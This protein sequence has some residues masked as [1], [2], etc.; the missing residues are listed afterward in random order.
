MNEFDLIDWIRAETLHGRHDVVLGIG[1]DAAVLD[2]PSDSQLVVSTDTLVAG[3]HFP[4]GTSPYD[5]GWKSLAVNLSDLAAM[6]ATPAWVSLALTL[7]NIDRD[8]LRGFLAGFNA[9]ATQHGVALIGGDCTRGPL[10]ITMTIQGLVPKGRAIVRSGAREGDALVLFGA[11]GRAA[12]GLRS[13][14]ARAVDARALP[15]ESSEAVIDVLALDRPEPLN[16]LT[17]LLRDHA[18]ALIDVSD[19]LLADLG[20][21]LKRSGVGCDVLLDAIPDWAGLRSRFGE[22][23][24]DMILSGGDDYALLAAIPGTSL[25]I[26]LREASALGIAATPIG[27]FR[28]EPGCRVTLDG[29]TVVLPQRSGFNHFA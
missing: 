12:A 25:G 23:A 16:G 13:Q 1:D 20:H 8:W 7:P 24:A 11:L 28:V 10:T 18:H 19:G 9:L 14:L 4:D 3:V 21:V 2:V 17:P 6:A 22:K 15:P 29:Q 5:I 26:V 27:R